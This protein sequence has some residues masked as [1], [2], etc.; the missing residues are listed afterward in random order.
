[1]S[2]TR[3]LHARVFGRVQGVW[4]RESTR[5]EAERIGDLAGYVRNVPDG[6][7][8]LVAEGPA[9]ACELLLQWCRNGPE[10]ARVDEVQVTWAD[11][12]GEYVRFE[13]AYW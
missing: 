10:L 4:F 5:R 1:M 7:V 2:G 6:S 13:V 8:E 3:R 9:D 12:G 11:P